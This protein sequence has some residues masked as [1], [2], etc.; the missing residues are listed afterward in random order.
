MCHSLSCL[1][2]SIFFCSVLP[3][4]LVAFLTP[5]HFHCT[6]WKKRSRYLNVL[7][8]VLNVPTQSLQQ[9]WIL[10]R[11]NTARYGKVRYDTTVLKF[12]WWIRWMFY[13]NFL[14]MGLVCRAVYR[15]ACAL[16]AQ[17]CC[18][19][20][21][22]TIVYCFLSNFSSPHST[23]LSRNATQRNMLQRVSP[24]SSHIHNAHNFQ[25]SSSNTQ[26]ICHSGPLTAF[27]SYQHIH[28]IAGP[29]DT[30]WSYESTCT[31]DILSDICEWA[32]PQRIQESLIHSLYSFIPI[33]D[34][35]AFGYPVLQSSPPPS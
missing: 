30:G 21:H 13:F 20:R 32:T 27:P 34:R 14:W 4:L 24:M 6:V 25:Y 35:T 12:V 18:A 22:P 15:A 26:E 11:L 23:A 28:F 1:I 33:S 10:E 8:V 16:N 9:H 29:H 19:A 31:R 7:K 5:E 3:V 2:F 17:L